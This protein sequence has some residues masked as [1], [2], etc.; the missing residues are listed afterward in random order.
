[1]SRDWRSLLGEDIDDVPAGFRSLVTPTFRGSTTIFKSAGL[2]GTPTTLELAARISRLE[3]SFGTFLTPS[4]QAAIAAVC[5]ALLNSGD[6]VLLPDSAYG[7]SKAFA[8]E[9][10]S[11]FGV[12]SSLY[13]PTADADIGRHFRNNTKLVW[14]ESPGSVTMEVQDVPAIVRAS[15]ERN[16]LVAIDNTYA[17]GVLF[18]A[19]GAGVDISMQALTKYLSGH[20][21]VFLASISVANNGLY[22]QLGR[23]LARF[24]MAVSPDDCSL[25]LRGMRTLAVRLDSIERSAL[26]VAQWLAARPEIEAVRHPALPGCPGHEIWR[27]DFSGSSGVFSIIFRPGIGNA[28]ILQ[29]VDRLK[30]FKIGYSWGGVT[31]LVVPYLSLKRTMGSENQRIV[32]LHV[33]LEP[34]ANILDDLSQAL[35]VLSL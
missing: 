34:L 8:S 11:R 9:I 31:S 18:D 4:G 32:R 27:R 20:S 6:H 1:M 23:T 30:L 22:D 16:I 15:H 10:L 24:G 29:F 12:E 33:G 17:A 25:A 14:C 7:P 19:F 21:D 26:M 5:F 3:G 28:A 13:L 2:H 35:R